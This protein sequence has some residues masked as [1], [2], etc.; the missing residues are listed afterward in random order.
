MKWTFISSL[1]HME[2]VFVEKNNNVLLGLISKK[3]RMNFCQW[4]TIFSETHAAELE[5][6]QI[7]KFKSHLSLLIEKNL[8]NLIFCLLNSLTFPSTLFSHTHQL[9]Y[10][11]IKQYFC[12]QRIS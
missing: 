1:S 11:W 7:G 2:E 3:T 8:K 5:G 10:L 9:K 6:Y 4:K 12:R